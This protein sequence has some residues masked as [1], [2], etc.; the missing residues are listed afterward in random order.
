MGFPDKTWP[1]VKKHGDVALKNGG[2]VSY[3]GW[4]SIMRTVLRPKMARDKILV[5]SEMYDLTVWLVLWPSPL[6][7]Q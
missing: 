3:C 5:L 4:G 2:S 1:N 6:A 7:N